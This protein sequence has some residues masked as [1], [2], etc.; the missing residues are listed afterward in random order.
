[1]LRANRLCQACSVTTRTW[2][3]CAGS[4]P[5]YRSWTNSSR[6]ATWATARRS[7]PRSARLQRLVDRAPVDH[8][9]HSPVVDEELVLG[10]TAGVARRSQAQK[11]PS[12]TSR[13]SPAPTA[14]CTKS[15]APRGSSAPARSPRRPSRVE[16]VT[17]DDRTD[18]L[19]DVSLP[20]RHPAND[21]HHR[22]PGPGTAHP[23]RPA[24]YRHPAAPPARAPA[25]RA[26]P[27][28]RVRASAG[29]GGYES[30][31]RAPSASITVPPNLRRAALLAA[32]EVVAHRSTP[33]SRQ[34]SRPD[35][36]APSRRRQRPRRWSSFMC[37]TMS[38]SRSIERGHRP[39]VQQRPRFEPMDAAEAGDE[40]RAFDLD[41][42]KVEIPE[43]GVHGGDWDGGPEAPCGGRGS[44]VVR[45]GP[46]RSPA[47]RSSGSSRAGGPSTS[48]DTRSSLAMSL[49][50]SASDDSSSSGL[51]SWSTASSAGDIGPA[52]GRIVVAAARGQGGAIGRA[53]QQP[54]AGGGGKLGCVHGAM[55]TGTRPA[56]NRSAA[57]VRPPRPPS[58]RRRRRGLFVGT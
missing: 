28:R 12:A 29:P 16:P 1:M 52:A 34:P 37:C 19:H 13:P 25:I 22:P 10:R 55:E 21:R 9:A 57:L 18:L 33:V 49:L 41:A 27:S 43:I 36:A 40:M 15:G 46:A 42:V 6:P 31:A 30:P 5:A 24:G 38:A 7:R 32:P 53:Q 47:R 11:A 35:R 3:R 58:S 45:A 51:A 4:A 2:S 14:S 26:R 44:L 8:V 23:G 50:C 54:G 20:W 39:V 17:A 56:V 48:S